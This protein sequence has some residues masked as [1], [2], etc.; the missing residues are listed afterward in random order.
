MV[1]GPD[2]NLRRDRLPPAGEVNRD[3]PTYGAAS[4][5]STQEPYG[6]GTGTGYE[7]GTRS[8]YQVRSDHR[9]QKDSRSSDEVR[10]DIERTRAELDATID[11]L[12]QRLSP[13]T[14]IHNVFDV[15][16]ENVNEGV[17][18]TVQVVRDNPIPAALIGIGVIWLIASQAGGRCRIPEVDLYEYEEYER[19]GEPT[20]TAI[21]SSPISP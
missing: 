4:A 1:K 10:A 5:T 15:L 14:I 17:R 3:N 20:Q 16:R 18:R 13:E 6:T 21:G 7:Y 9:A 2:D 11:A 19:F 8:D 12:H